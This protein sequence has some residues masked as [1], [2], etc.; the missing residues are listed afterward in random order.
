MFEGIIFQLGV[1]LVFA[2]IL[3]EIT[4]RLG[5]SALVGQILAGIIAGPVLGWVHPN[6]ILEFFSFLGLIILVFLIGLETKVDDLRKDVYIGIA[7]AASGSLLTFVAGFL[8]GEMIFGSFSIGLAIGV[9]MIS[10]S[11]AIPIKILIDRKEY[12]THTGRIF[13]IMAIADD[14]IAILAL[15]L[16]VSYVSVH[17]ISLTYITSLFLAILGFIFFIL[18]FGDKAIN[19][20]IGVVQKS[21]DP[22]ILFTIPLAL[23][24]FI[25]IWSEHIGL[26]AITG[27]FIAGMAM[28]RSY[29]RES[30]IQPKMK[31]FG[32]SIAIPIF[33]AYSSIFVDLSTFVAYWYL[34]VVI[35]IV[36]ILSKAIGSGFMSRY[37]GFDKKSQA[38]ISIG[39]IPRGEYGIVVSQ[40]ALAAGIIT[41]QIYTL[42]ISFIVLTV[43]LTPI[44]FKLLDSK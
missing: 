43:I 26:A 37:F 14:V 36:G 5:V 31:T 41:G 34:I 13:V 42:M 11:T 24:F 32:Y 16:L 2:V 27:A 25:S 7:L 6:N 19:R 8:L 29:F 17:S 33:F 38:I 3:G 10:T 23:A 28:S 35:L 18:T 20:I 44:F 15:S 21:R 1:L 30:I 4:S 22:E 39:M 9:A 40:I 12:H